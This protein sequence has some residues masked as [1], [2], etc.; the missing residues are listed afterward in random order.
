MP[1]S[2]P[3]QARR[4]SAETEEVLATLQAEVER[5]RQD[6][7]QLQKQT[8]AVAEANAHAAELMVEIEEARALLE[9][10]NQQL[11]QHNAFIRQTFGRYL[12][13]DVVKSLLESPEGLVLGGERRKLT[14][15]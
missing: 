14:L 13:N 8:E 10:Q 1:H 11:E 5:L 7:T 3:T 15:V 12:T 4:A 6:N 9:E 2:Q